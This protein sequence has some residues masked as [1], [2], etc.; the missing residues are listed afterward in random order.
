ME[1]RQDQKAM[2]D[3]GEA[4]DDVAE[5]CQYMRDRFAEQERQYQR[6]HRR[7][8]RTLCGLALVGLLLAFVLAHLWYAWK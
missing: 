1:L 5:F 4:T 2:D 7:R 8:I 3:V 6:D